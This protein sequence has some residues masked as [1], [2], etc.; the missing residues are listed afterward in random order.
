MVVGMPFCMVA[1]WLN[2]SLFIQGVVYLI[3]GYDLVGYWLESFTY[4]AIPHATWESSG[5]I[6]CAYV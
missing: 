4:A 6:Y 1:W 5:P 2:V 3:A